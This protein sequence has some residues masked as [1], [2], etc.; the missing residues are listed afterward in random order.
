MHLK[1]QL[2]ESDMA[3]QLL[4]IQELRT[5]NGYTEMFQTKKR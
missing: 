1:R 4:E 5:I 2:Q 3:N